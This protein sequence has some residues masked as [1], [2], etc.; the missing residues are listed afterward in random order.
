MTEPHR[1]IEA[2]K[3]SHKLF[4]ASDSRH[5]AVVEPDRS[6]VVWNTDTDERTVIRPPTPTMSLLWAPDRSR[7]AV[8]GVDGYVRVYE[9][10]TGSLVATFS[11]SGSDPAA[12]R[13][14]A[15]AVP[16]SPSSRPSPDDGHSAAVVTRMTV[17]IGRVRD[18][19][20]PRGAVVRAIEAETGTLVQVESDGNVTIEADDSDAVAAAQQ[21]V[22]DVVDPP[23]LAVGDRFH[24]RVASITS[25]G[26]F[27]N[28]VPGRD[29]LLHVNKL[30]RGERVTDVS[31][32][33]SMGDQVEVIVENILDNG[34][35]SL[36][37][38]P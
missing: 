36:A 15:S 27:V 1:P 4:W 20:G 29:G 30:G 25:Y 12:D 18:V 35:I 7:V 5:L 10:T 17:P 21:M 11:G 19:I 32:V 31:S 34:K 33:L 13:P 8:T 23:P 3:G 6:I 38:A 9:V 26:A 28:L 2:T 37:L 22:L 14:D 16:P 24:G